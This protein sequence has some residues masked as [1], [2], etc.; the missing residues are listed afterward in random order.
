MRR[1]E[2]VGGM[3]VA[4]ASVLGAPVVRAQQPERIRRIG[5]LLPYNEGDPVGGRFHAALRQGLAELGWREGRN[6]QIDTRWAPRS[7]EQVPLLIKELLDL[8]PELLAT[9]TVRLTRVKHHA[10]RSRPGNKGH[11]A[12]LKM[13]G[14]VK[15][16]CRS[17]YRGHR[18]SHQ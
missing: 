2:F 4:A 12:I 9:G 14:L 16:A 13:L 15:R 17:R 8:R 5:V 18:R 6:L 1:R 10:G 3:G 7:P 11:G